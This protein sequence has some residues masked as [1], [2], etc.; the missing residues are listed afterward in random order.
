[1]QVLL[2]AI[3]KVLERARLIEENRRYR[4]HLEDEVRRRTAELEEANAALRREIEAREKAEHERAALR[5]QLHQAQKMEAVGLLA[6]GVAH[7]FNNLLMVI[8]CYAEFVREKLPAGDLALPDI[9]RIK[10]AAGQAAGV[11]RSLLTFSRKLPPEREPISLATVVTNATRLLGRLLPASVEFVVEPMP[12]PELWV[13]ADATQLQQI[14]L[15]LAVNARDAMPDG[16]TLRLAAE[17]ASAAEAGPDAESTDAP[18]AWAR[19]TISDTGAGMTPEVRDRIFEPFFTTKPAGQ[20]TGLGLAIV[21]S[22]VTE[23]EGRVHLESHPGRGTTF[24]VLLPCIDKTKPAQPDVRRAAAGAGDGELVLVAEDNEM[25]RAALTTSLL[26]HGYQVAQA[27]DGPSLIGSYDRHGPGVKLLVIDVDLP[28]RGGIDCL[29][30][31]RGRQSRIPAILITG[32]IERELDDELDDDTVVLRKPLRMVELAE[33][34]RRML[35]ARQNRENQ[36]T[37]GAGDH[38]ANRIHR[39]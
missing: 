16:G 23:H 9:E 25:V 31:I 3:N 1:M 6:G 38:G 19:L 10:Q 7:D 13:H 8:E 14:T 36:A 12:E 18:T 24:H 11:T 15:N 37:G 17:S 5:E 4:E 33:T 20:G 39:G 30:E 22:I 28:V 34:V 27:K 35:A 26:S 29:H 32:H 2:H 21:H